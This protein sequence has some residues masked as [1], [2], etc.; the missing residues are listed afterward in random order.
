M[1]R[2]PFDDRL[3]AIRDWAKRPHRASPSPT[4]LR[5]ARS[6]RRGRGALLGAATLL[7]SLAAIAVFTEGRGSGSHGG[8]R[9][10]EPA[11]S[12]P[13]ASAGGRVV[14]LVLTSGTRLYLV[15]PAE[16][17]IDRRREVEP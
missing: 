9:S 5:R 13:R 1:N 8:T 16:A 3:E 14:S 7:I 12:M 17:S 4:E 6:R 2:D 15:V 10:A 11:A